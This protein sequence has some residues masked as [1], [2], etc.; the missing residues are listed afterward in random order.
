MLKRRVVTKQGNILVR[1]EKN[2]MKM[3]QS[4]LALVFLLCLIF[5]R[6]AYAYI[7]PG[8]GSYIFQL[9]LGAFFGFL[10]LMRI[11][12]SKIKLFLMKIFSAD[13]HNEHNDKFDD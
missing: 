12:W 2:I 10:F 3:L 9:L 11:F 8:T 6:K 4:R 5:S 1:K 7:D 13:R